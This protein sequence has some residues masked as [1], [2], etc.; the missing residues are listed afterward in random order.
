MIGFAV[1][2]RGDQGLDD[3]DGSVVGAGVAPGFQRMRLRHL[4][5][6][7]L[8][9]LVLVKPDADSE[10]H[11]AHRA[12]KIEIAR[13]GIAGITAEN[14]QHVDIA[15]VHL[16]NQV[17]QRIDS[18]D[19]LGLDRI[20][21]HCRS[22]LELGVNGMGQRMNLRRLR[23]AD[24]DQPAGPGGLEIARGGVEPV[25]GIHVP[26]HFQCRLEV[27]IA[28]AT[29]ATVKSQMTGQYRG[30]LRDVWA[31]NR[32]PTIRHRPGRAG[33][34][35]GDV[36]AVH[37]M[38]R[39]RVRFHTAGAEEILCI[40]NTARI[41]DKEIAV[42]R[43]DHR[44]LGKIVQ[45]VALRA[46]GQL[47]ALADVVTP[48][49]VELMPGRQ[50]QFRQKRTNLRRQSRRGYRLGEQHQPFAL[51]VA[52]G[53]HLVGHHIGKPAPGG[54]VAFATED[55]GPIR[56]VQAQDRRLRDR[57]GV[58]QTGGMIGI[59]LD[60]GGP[61]FVLLN[62]D[63]AGESAQDKRR[64]IIQ[65]FARRQEF[66]LL[67]VGNDLLLRRLHATGQP[68]QCQRCPHDLQKS[69]AAEAPRPLRRRRREL[70]RQ[71]R[72]KFRRL[73]QFLQ[74]LPIVPAT[75]TRQPG[76]LLDRQ[77]IRLIHGHDVYRWHV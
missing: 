53:L 31:G 19:R 6:T 66:R 70:I 73:G 24:E 13:S 29:G 75:P 14:H 20:A 8:R 37:R 48:D 49:G 56:I 12:G 23:F 62:N 27:E 39:R 44:R 54:D 45:H 4:P 11:F 60:L 30:K 67:H 63:P 17:A 7:Q 61:A 16:A 58:P 77:G 32:Q 72:L 46:E 1:V 68:A 15:G 69:S 25:R 43:N 36:Q 38:R 71:T 51:L 18:D 26:G 3:R 76:K 21:C 55:L 42:Q 41:I 35:L 5:V 52:L 47:R 74:A 10:P 22:A 64:R 50:R 33:R 57:V 34:S 2:E 40:A 59:A 28:E 65:R 9:S